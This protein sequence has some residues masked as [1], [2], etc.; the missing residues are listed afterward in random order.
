MFFSIFYKE[1]LKIRYYIAAALLLNV[2][3]I[4]YLFFDLKELF[5]NDPPIMAW[6]GAIH[7]HTIYYAKVKYLLPA[8]GL[9]IGLA[10]FAPEMN[11]NRL[12]LSLHLPVP[13]NRLLICYLAIGLFSA[14]V[15]GIIDLFMLSVT[16]RHFFPM[17]VMH[18]AQ[19]TSL[20]WFFAGLIAYLS[21][22]QII[23]EPRWPRRIIYGL[24]FSGFIGF[25]FL[26]NDYNTYQHVVT[27]L[28]CA[29]LLLIPATILP[30]YRFNNGVK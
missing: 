30:L 24:T 4:V 23:L 26:G 1:W 18:S 10:Q 19:I 28:L 2:A 11:K 27:K 8:S 13:P 22:T 12:R 17:E 25:F 5:R 20:P 15:I 21:T 9:L 3:I 14:I 6:Y 29:S 16:I 7:I